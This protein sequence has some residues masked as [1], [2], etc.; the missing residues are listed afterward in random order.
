MKK[1]SRSKKNTN[2][3]K[4]Q[5]IGLIIIVIVLLHIIRKCDFDDFKDKSWQ[6]SDTIP[7]ICENLKLS[8][9]ECT[10]KIEELRKDISQNV[11]TIP[12]IG[13]IKEKYSCIEG[14]L[15]INRFSYKSFFVEHSGWPEKGEKFAIYNDDE[16]R[17]KWFDLIERD[18]YMDVLETSDNKTKHKSFSI[19]LKNEEY[20]RFN[21]LY[22]KAKNSKKNHVG[23]LSI[24]DV[25]FRDEEKFFYSANALFREN[26]KDS[27][28]FI[29]LFESDCE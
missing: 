14:T 6:P 8:K 15:S 24:T 27:N 11:Q 5:Y 16:E 10:K 23:E 28:N 17:L 25:Y 20:K 13:D 18:L 3:N 4:G 29:S 12:N 21:T 19:E 1:K 26:M 2:Y 7:A 9:S 22:K